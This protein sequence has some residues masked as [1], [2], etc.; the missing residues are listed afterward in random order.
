MI[1]ITIITI[2]TIILYLKKIKINIFIIIKV[3]QSSVE[4]IAISLF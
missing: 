3:D 2:I 1:I 4:V